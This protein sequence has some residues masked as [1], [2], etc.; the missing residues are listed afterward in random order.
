MLVSLA[1]SSLQGAAYI[2]ID[3]RIFADEFGY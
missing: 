2:F 1:G 3:D